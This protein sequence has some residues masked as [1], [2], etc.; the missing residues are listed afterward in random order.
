M[1]FIPQS[2]Q[3]KTWEELQSLTE[4]MSDCDP[5]ELRLKEDTQFYDLYKELVPREIALE[6]IKRQIGNNS[7]ALINNNF[8]YTRTLELLP[9]VKH[10]CLWSLTGPLNE[11]TIKEVVGSKFPKKDWCKS[12]R[13]LNFKSVPEMWHCHIFVKN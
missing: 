9:K 11:D 13:K 7:I 5:R 2:K 12:E 10:Y 6:I 4:Y 8:P 3:P 1:D